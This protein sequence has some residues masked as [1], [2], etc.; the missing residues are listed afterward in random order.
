MRMSILL[1]LVLGAPTPAAAQRPTGYPRSYDALIAA[2]QA[3][4][5]VHVFGNADS[6]A[7]QP[8][9]AAFR[10]T[11][12]GVA[13]R[14]DDLESRDIYRRVVADAAARRPGA[15]LV[16]SSGMDLQA[17]LIN[18]GYAQA[19][20]SPEKPALPATAV[21]KNMGYGVTAEPVAF[22]V[23]RRLVPP[24]L[25]PRTHEAFERLL[26]S[27]RAAL[28]GKVATYDPAQS[29]VGYMYL[30]E[31]QAITRDTR[32]LVQAIAATRP[33][34]SRTTE[35]MLDAI[36]AGRVA[37]AYNVVGPYALAR[38]RRDPRIGV[39]FPRDYTIVASRVAFIARDARRPAAAKLFLDF[40]LSRTGQTLLAREWLLPVRA[41]VR[42][43]RLSR[44][45]QRP[46][47]VGPQLL[48]NLD[49][50]KRRRFLTDWRAILAEGAKTP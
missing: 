35:P 47:R 14:Y 13:V 45:Q 19:Y 36:A 3:E 7:M 28:T 1:M 43:P 4:R 11:Y 8:L 27:R 42:A 20:L 37:I 12:P 10:R 15:D 49:S 2:A 31:D 21:W 22:V 16:W 5:G 38:A 29:N 33:M 24:T 46:I 25:V 26:R 41:D 32:S 39:V 50:I 34:L 6:A 44:E 40:L 30:S 48:V 9:I 17:K 23:N 18:D